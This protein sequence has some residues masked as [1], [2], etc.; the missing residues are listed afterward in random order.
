MEPQNIYKIKIKFQQIHLI[1]QQ[2]GSILQKL[3]IISVYSL[4]VLNKIS[5]IFLFYFQ[6]IMMINY[7]YYGNFVKKVG[8]FKTS[9]FVQI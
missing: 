4:E 8:V 2:Y 3:Q 5:S 1:I 9:S 6:Y 7:F